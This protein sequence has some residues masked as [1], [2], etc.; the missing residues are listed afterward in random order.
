MTVIYGQDAVGLAYP[1]MTHLLTGTCFLFPKEGIHG[2]QGNKS[3]IKR[4]RLILMKPTGGDSKNV[5]GGIGF[6]VLPTVRRR[7][8]RLLRRDQCFSR[9]LFLDTI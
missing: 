4:R 9:Q 2:V 6:N 5:D 1:L 7:L 8:V 3:S